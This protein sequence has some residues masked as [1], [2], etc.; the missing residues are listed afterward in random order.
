M[1]AW[2]GQDPEAVEHKTILE[3]SMQIAGHIIMVD[4]PHDDGRY[5]CT[6]GTLFWHQELGYTTELR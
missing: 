2:K 5:R 1:V 3:L 6:V 4:E